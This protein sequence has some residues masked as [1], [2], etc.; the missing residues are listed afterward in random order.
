MSREPGA[1][2]PLSVIIPTFNEEETI[3]DCLASVAFADE[4]LVVDS[5]STD[6]T[7][8]IAR[9]R[10]A[11]VVQRE[12]GYS[13]QQKN[14]AIPQARHEWVLLVDADER[15]APGLRQELQELLAR[16][17]SADGYWIRRA[18]HFLG[19]RIRHC[20][21]GT[22]RV[23]RLFRRDVARY[24][25]RQV[26]AEIDL[27]GPLPTLEHPLEHHTF[28]SWSQYWR[29]LDLYSE[30]G[31]RQMFQEGKRTDGVQI[32]LRPVGRFIRMYILR[33]GFLEGTHGVVLSMLGAFTVYLKHA[34]LWEMQRTAG[35]PAARAAD[36]AG[37]AHPAGAPGAAGPSASEAGPLLREQIG[38]MVDEERARR[39]R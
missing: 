6:R 11:R 27:P 29:K 28:R 17:P 19:K 26:H 21:W 36:T 3:E 7:V 39:V 38:R 16:G 30:W 34:R 1:P 14:W 15:V 33:F 10:G 32:L 20:G 5:F 25:D 31:A 2:R 4:V 9:A 23:I 35:A 13:A 22:D 8:E 12:Y 37:G 24:Q 18:N